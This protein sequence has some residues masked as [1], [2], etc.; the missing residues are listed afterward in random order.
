[1][2]DS[3]PVGRAGH[4]ETMCVQW[5]SRHH[6][7]TARF[8]ASLHCEHRSNKPAVRQPDNAANG[9]RRFIARLVARWFLPSLPPICVNSG[10][11]IYPSKPYPS[12]VRLQV[13]F[14]RFG[15][16]QSAGNLWDDFL[17]M[18]QLKE[19]FKKGVRANPP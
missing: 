12:Q 18:L 5:Q 6:S 10:E 3:G 15:R 11:Q 17:T 14:R 19:I 4:A 1:M 2:Q 8:K 9:T 13:F 7:E 16:T